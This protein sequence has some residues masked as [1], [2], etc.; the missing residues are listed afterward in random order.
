MQIVHKPWEGI[1]EIVYNMNTVSWADGHLHR[2]SHTFRLEFD[3]KSSELT[4]W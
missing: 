4:V 2:Q 1:Q 3:K